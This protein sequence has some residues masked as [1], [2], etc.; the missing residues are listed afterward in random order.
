MKNWRIC[1]AVQVHFSRFLLGSRA[2]GAESMCL[3]RRPGTHSGDCSSSEQ[4]VVA[5]ARFFIGVET[6]RGTSRMHTLYRFPRAIQTFVSRM[7]VLASIR[8][9]WGFGEAIA[10]EGEMKICENKKNIEI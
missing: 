4:K 5:F 3:A 2:N 10:R 6:Q 9:A 8:H 1:G 7:S